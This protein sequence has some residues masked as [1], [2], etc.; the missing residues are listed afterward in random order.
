MLG[1]ETEAR[2]PTAARKSP[3]ALALPLVPHLLIW[4]RL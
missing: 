3:R 2:T 4:G 1:E